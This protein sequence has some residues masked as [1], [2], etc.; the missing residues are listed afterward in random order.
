MCDFCEN[1]WKDWDGFSGNLDNQGFPDLTDFVV[2]KQLIATFAYDC[3]RTPVNLPI[4]MNN[5]S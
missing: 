2:K 4:S 3:D 1:N 5:N